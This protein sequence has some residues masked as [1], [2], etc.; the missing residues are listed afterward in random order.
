MPTGLIAKVSSKKR[1]ISKSSKAD[2]YFPVA[3]IHR[4][5]KEEHK[6]YRIGVGAAVYTASVLEYLCGNLFICLHNT[7]IN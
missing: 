6:K 4:L 5:M 2:V 7:L 1:K 3:R